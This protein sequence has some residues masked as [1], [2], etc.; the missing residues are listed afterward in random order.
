MI[1]REMNAPV[2]R[3]PEF[4]GNWR[5]KTMRELLEE[6]V[7]CEHKTAP[8]IDK[9]EYLVV[10]TNNVKNGQLD[11]SEIKFTTKAGFKEWT[12]RGVPK[13]GEIL[14]TREAPAGESCLVPKN[15]KIC[16]GQRMV[17]LKPKTELTSGEYISVYLQSDTAKRRISNLS[18]G[19]TVTRINITDI[20]KIECPITSLPEQQKIASF[21]TTIDTKIQQ[22]KKKKA[23][24]ETY[25]KGVMQQ[26]FKQQIRFRDEEGKAFPDWE[27]V[28]L[29]EVAERITRKNKENNT[30]VLTISAQDGL[31]N[32]QEFFNKSVSARNVS[33]YYLLHKDEFAYNKSYSK[34]YPMGAI[35]RLSRYEKGVLSTLY[36]CFKI[37]QKNSEGYFEQYF[38]SGSFNKELHKIAQ[39][40]ARNH[41]LLNVSVVEF[42]N[43]TN[44]PRPSLKEQNKIKDFL[45]SLDAKINEV[46]KQ[47]RKLQSFKRGL[48][49]KMF[50]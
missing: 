36:I 7:D 5:K 24:L 18:I 17:L 39:E 3:F 25:K 27:I 10:R 29:Q 35:K 8:Y 13:Y 37:R 50:M 9:S 21:L 11:T 32:Q 41:G 20:Y 43:S 46:S 4:R 28:K 40:G 49:Q 23:L 44:L 19:T 42:F 30:N 2:L 15:V 14:F 6:L 22:L 12:K 34:G 31:I 16:L 1:T 45:S 38:E 47:F 33:G 26:I 48:L